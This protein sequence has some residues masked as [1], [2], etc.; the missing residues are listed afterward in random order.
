MN[1]FKNSNGKTY[2]IIRQCLNYSLLRQIGTNEY[3]VAYLLKN[4]SWVQGYYFV[5]FSA[6][7]EDF[8]KRSSTAL[9]Y[10]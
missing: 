1:L 4:D 8:N 3:V 7:I 2:E 5:G 9:K 10:C 6:A